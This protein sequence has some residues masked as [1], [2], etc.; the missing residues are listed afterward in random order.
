VGVSAVHPW[1]ERFPRLWAALEWISVPVIGSMLFWLFS[2]L[3]ITVPAALV[4]LYAVMAALIRP[5]SG[6]LIGRFWRGF[7]RTFGRALLLGLLDGLV[8][9]ILIT[10]IRFFWSPGTPVGKVAAYLLG[11]LGAVVALANVYLWPLLAWYPQPMSKLL[12]RSFLLAAAHPFHALGG[13][14]AGLTALVLL[15]LLPGVL[16]STVVM[17]G[18]GLFVLMTGWAAWQAMKR[19]AGPADEF[20]E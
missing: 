4:G 1:G 17:L 19:Y 13:L 11:S 6:D 10:D 12:K 18:P 16:K 7:L 20:A 14:A 2:A 8:I 5:V 3:I 15:S 9:L